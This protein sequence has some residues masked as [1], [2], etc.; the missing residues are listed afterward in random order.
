MNGPE[1]TGRGKNVPAGD[2]HQYSIPNDLAD[3][4]KLPK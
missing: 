3:T 1:L 4:Q 2:E